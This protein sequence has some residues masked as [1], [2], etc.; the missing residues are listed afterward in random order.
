M[1]PT[2]GTIVHYALS[3]HDAAEVNARREHSHEGGP[4]HIHANGTK[5]GD[6]YPAMIVRTWAG[7]SVQLQVFID[8]D[9]TLWAT[10]VPECQTGH[11]ERCWAWPPMW[12]YRVG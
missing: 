4:K 11:A 1:I 7:S 12:S 5:A 8:G 6:V 10:S 3:E 9:F 2:I